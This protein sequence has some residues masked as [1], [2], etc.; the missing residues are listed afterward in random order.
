MANP[1]SSGNIA[2]DKKATIIIKKKSGDVKLTC[3][4]NPE[5]YT[6][7]RD[8]DWQ[9]Q[10]IKGQNVA[11][12]EFRGGGPSR[13]TLT[14]L[15]DTTSEE[16]VTDVRDHTKKLW[17]ASRIDQDAKN[18]TTN[19]G[20]PPR[21]VF[22]WGRAWSFEAIINSISE[23]FVL[24]NEDGVPLRSNVTVSLTQVKDDTTF[25]RQNPTSGGTPGK[26]YTVREG[27]RLDLIAA[28]YYNKPMLWRY[29]AEH[30]D[31]DNPR[32]LVPGQQLLIPELP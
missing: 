26:V 21:V 13:T 17:D 32:E 31:I 19:K 9:L 16:S 28:Q 24:F 29:I 4:F 14:L 8:V 7:S 23:E 12:S 15:F 27:D 5:R 3:H 1:G 22:I 30:N 20:E 18:N 25:G 11:A 6:V 10:P 2:N